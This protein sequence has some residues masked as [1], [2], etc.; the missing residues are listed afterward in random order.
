MDNNIEIDIELREKWLQ[1]LESGE[2]EQGSSYLRTC[3][4]EFCCLGVLAALS[5]VE[6]HQR[7]GEAK[8]VFQYETETGAEQFAFS[9]R[10]LNMRVGILGYATDLAEMNDTG[11]SFAE[12]AAYIREQG[13]RNEQ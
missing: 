11:S 9:D 12:I 4:D 6:W 8:R 7:T 3:N 5:G 2:Y 1:A 10:A 13:I